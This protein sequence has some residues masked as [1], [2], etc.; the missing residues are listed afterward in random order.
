[1]FALSPLP[2]IGKLSIAIYFVHF[3]V[4]C[5]WKIVDAQYSL[6]LNFSSLLVFFLYPISIIEARGTGGITICY[7]DSYRAQRGFEYPAQYRVD[8]VHT[9]VGSGNFKILM[10]IGKGDA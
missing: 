5:L 8:H 2:W 9:A 1:M 6:G 7:A 4:Q 3:P 10:G